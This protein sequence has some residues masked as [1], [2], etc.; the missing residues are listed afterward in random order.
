MAPSRKNLSAVFLLLV[1]TAAWMDASV[2]D[3]P[4]AHHLS[5]NYKG[6]CWTLINDDDCK[7]VCEEE[8]IDNIDGLCVYFQCWCQTGCTSETVAAAASAPIRQ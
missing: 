2:G 6:A 8:S 3:Y 1:V 5:G 4:C 7:R